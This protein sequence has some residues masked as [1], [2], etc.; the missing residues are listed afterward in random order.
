MEKAVWEIEHPVQNLIVHPINHIQDN[1]TVTEGVF[2]GS[3]IVL[4]MIGLA[5]FTGKKDKKEIVFEV[6]EEQLPK[7]ESKK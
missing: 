3:S 4:A 6:D 1:Y 2:Y 5:A 7:K